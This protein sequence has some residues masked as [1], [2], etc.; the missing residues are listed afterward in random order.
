[1]KFYIKVPSCGVLCS[2]TNTEQKNYIC[3][4]AA[5]SLSG[6]LGEWMAIN[7]RT[8]NMKSPVAA[9]ILESFE[10]RPADF[11]YL[12]KGLIISAQS[13]VLNGDTLCVELTD[14][15]LHGIGDGGHTYRA[16]QMIREAGKLSKECFVRI[17]VRTNLSLAEVINMVAANN[18]VV[19]VDNRSLEDLQGSY[20]ILKGMLSHEAFFGRVQFK[21][22]QTSDDGKMINVDKILAILMMFSPWYD[23]S[24][25][26]EDY[27]IHYSQTLNVQKRFMAQDREEREQMLRDME[28]VI[29]DIFV[30]WDRIETELP[31][32]KGKRGHKHPFQDVSYTKYKDGC[33]VGKSLF[34]QNDLEYIIPEGIIYPILAAFHILIEQSESTGKYQW[35]TD[36]FEMWNT[37][38]EDIA[39]QVLG[40]NTMSP[41]KFGKSSMV[42]RALQ[43]TV[44]LHL[45]RN[46]ISAEGQKTTTEERFKALY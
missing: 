28:P 19:Q 8:Q 37:I 3:Y 34:Y 41:A 6:E 2:P 23:H 7:P 40:Y 38:R 29:H 9:D 46:R 21:M 22:N 45:L 20:D 31:Q 26:S 30:L 4:A 10:K 42:Y 1:M 36:P 39:R 14:P 32:G 44:A 18:N 15:E 25:T 24:E 17:D 35:K 13:A 12:N 27:P 5:D 33:V 43:L 16:I 11:Y